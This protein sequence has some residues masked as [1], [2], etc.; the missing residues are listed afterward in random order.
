[1]RHRAQAIFNKEVNLVEETFIANEK[2]KYLIIEKKPL[3]IG[4]NKTYPSDKFNKN[5][6]ITSQPKNSVIDIPIS[7]LA[8]IFGLNNKNKTANIKST[9]VFVNRE[10]EF[11]PPIGNNA[12]FSDKAKLTTNIIYNRHLKPLEKEKYMPIN[13]FLSQFVSQDDINKI[14]LYHMLDIDYESLEILKAKCKE[15]KEASSRLNSKSNQEQSN[16]EGIIS[17][18][19]SIFFEK[20]LSKLTKNEENI[21]KFIQN[22]DKV[23]GISYDKGGAKV[24]FKQD[25]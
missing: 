25:Y 1:M 9:S 18:E 21:Q 22:I 23:K 19:N 16:E 2:E 20:I 4:N 12:F 14:E 10:D 15:F 13:Q 3:Y 24:Y 7:S 5:I 8:S 11:Q 6:K 17:S